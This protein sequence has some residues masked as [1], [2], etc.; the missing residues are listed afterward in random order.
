MLLAAKATS[1]LNV[2]PHLAVFG[3]FFAAV[4]LTIAYD[5]RFALAVC[6]VLAVLTS[7]QMRLGVGG[8]LA[9]WAVARRWCSSSA[10]CGPAASSS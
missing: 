7:M 5:Q 2:N 10:R 4:A 9:L 6:G 8:L 3:V 1:L